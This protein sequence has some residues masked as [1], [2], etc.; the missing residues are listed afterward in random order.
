MAETKRCPY[1]GKEILAVAKKCK[2]CGKWLDG[3]R[4]DSNSV[5]DSE[6]N[7]PIVSLPVSLQNQA[8]DNIE[9]IENAEINLNPQPMINCPHCGKEIN[10]FAKKCKYCGEWLQKKCPYCGEW[11]QES[12]MRCKHCG[13]WLNKFA[14]ENYERKNGIQ[15]PV[16][17]KTEEQSDEDNKVSL[18]DAIQEHEDKKNAGCLMWGELI[19]IGI[20]VGLVYG[21]KWWEYIVAYIIASILL[22][23]RI[24]RI[25]YCIGAS[26]VWGFI[27]LCLS[28]WIFNESDWEE[29]SRLINQDF[30]DYWWFALIV[31]IISLG[32]HWPAMKSGFS[33]ND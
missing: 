11:I 14:K 15:Q 1:C 31:F 13:C 6:E 25:L 18:E 2:Y 20:I 16:V 4:G 10:A 12:A 8:D 3:N 27:G 9:V 26:L 33:I 28:P 7:L 30:S 22:S 5:N 32:F 23:I 17:A 29:L 24:L 19:V 21:W